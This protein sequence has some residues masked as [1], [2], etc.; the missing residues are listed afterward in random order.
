MS[1]RIEGPEVRDVFVFRTD[2]DTKHKVEAL[3]TFLSDHPVIAS[4]SVD[5]ADADNVLRIVRCGELT[6]GEVIEILKL[7]GFFCEA[8]P[9]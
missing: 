4:W 6:E 5:M 3:K 9:D 1:Q 8:L 2:I 7:Q